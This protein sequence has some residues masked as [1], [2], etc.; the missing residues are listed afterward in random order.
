MI[1]KTMSMLVGN[2]LKYSGRNGVSSQQFTLKVFILYL[3][4]NLR[5][6]QDRRYIHRKNKIVCGIFC[7]LKINYKASF[8]VPN[9]LSCSVWPP[10]LWAASLHSF[11]SKEQVS[12]NFM[13]AVTVW[14]DFGVQ[15]YKICHYLYFFPFYLP[16]SD[17]TGCHVLGLKTMGSQKMLDVTLWLNNNNIKKKGFIYQ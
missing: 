3:F 2:I 15:E 7:H 4:I 12:S 10:Q 14:S 17:G 13:A 8:L 9:M 6:F 16:W 1:I 11:S 5:L